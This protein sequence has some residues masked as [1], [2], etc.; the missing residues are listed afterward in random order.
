MQGVLGR[1]PWSLL[2]AVAGLL[3]MGVVVLQDP[4]GES[5]AATR[6]IVWISLA[7]PAMGLAAWIP[8]RFWKPWSPVLYAGTLLLLILVLFLPAR[9]GSH[10]WVPLG[11]F[12]VQPS[13]FAKLSFVLALANHLMHQH[14]HRTLR[15]L[16]VP[17]MLAIV[18]VFLILK[19][20]DLGTAMLF[21]PVLFAMLLAAGARLRHLAGAVVVAALLSPGLWMVMSAE[22]KS[23]VTALFTQEDGGPPPKGDGYHLHQSKQVIALGAVWGS[24]VHGPVV[25]DPFAY[26]LPAART[27]FVFCLSAERWGLPGVGLLLGMYLLIFVRGLQIAAATREPFGRLVAVGVVTLIAGQVLINTGMTVGLMPITGLTLPLVSYGGSSL[28]GT[29]LAVGLLIN[30]AVR[31]GYE[32]TGGCFRFDA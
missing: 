14:R 15:G 1:I 22:Q 26:H 28:L 12:S 32:V 23:R 29:C 8:Y 16:S 9:H 13:E 6:Q 25:S 17:L 18:P 4:G 30:V 31:P 20:P 21:L 19:E 5:D 7:I 11:V 27:D 10:R 24:A 2:L 3:A